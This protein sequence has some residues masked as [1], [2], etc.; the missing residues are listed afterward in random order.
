MGACAVDACHVCVDM[1]VFHESVSMCVGVHISACFDVC[2]HCTT[3][4]HSTHTKQKR[5]FHTHTHTHTHTNIDARHRHELTSS[6]LTSHVYCLKQTIMLGPWG[7][8]VFSCVAVCV[9]VSM[10]V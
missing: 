9:H 2:T 8:Y 3:A 10:C 7:M 5:D 4:P 1:C 6:A